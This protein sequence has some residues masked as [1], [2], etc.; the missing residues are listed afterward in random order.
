MDKIINPKSS[1][2]N[3]KSKIVNLLIAA[4]I[5]FNACG[6]WIDVVPD[7]IAT[8]DM[9]FNSRVQALKYLK[10]CYSFMMPDN[11]GNINQDPAMLGDE[12]WTTIAAQPIYSYTGLYLAQGMMSATSPL[13]ERWGHCYQALRDCNIFM[14]NV[15]RAPDLPAWERDQWIAEAKVLKAYYHF[16]LVRM[17][18]PVPI[19]RENIPVSADVSK[20]KVVR[21]PVDDCFRY[22]V[23]LLDE[24]IASDALPSQVLDENRELGRITKPIAMALK[25]KILV[26][27]A[28][29]LYNGNSDFETLCNHDGTQ[30]FNATYDETKWQKAVVACKEAIDACFDANIQLYEF[31]NTGNNPLT[32][33]I[34]TRMSL[35]NAFTL[36]WNSEIIWAN[37]QSIIA[38]NRW[39]GTGR[40]LQTYAGV[41]LNPSFREN[42]EAHRSLGVPLHIAEIFYTNHGVPLAE[43]R[44][45][46]FS[47]RY[48]L[49]TALAAERLY[50]K[51]GNV[52]VD[53]HFDR[54]PRFYAWVGFDCGIWY[55][56][57]RYDDQVEL[58]TLECKGGDVDRLWGTGVGYLPKKYIHYT[59]MVT[60]NTY[61]ISVTTYPWP[62]MR[63]SEL[64][65]LYA[66]AINEA[67]G[68]AEK[69]SVE[70]FEYIDRVRKRAGL[71]GIKASWSAYSKQPNKFATKEGMREIIRQERMI[72]LAFEGHRFWDVRRWKTAPQVYSVPI[73]GWSVLERETNDFYQR[74]VVY[75]KKFR[76]RD[77]FWP[78]RNS[79]LDRNPNLVQ[80]IGW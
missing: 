62:L 37:T 5:G 28:S 34:A 2:V 67:E 36:R 26:T 19:I 14:E 42:Y 65:L 7:G 31:P 20:V 23:E 46:D 57:G 60:D 45:R 11:S 68:P 9:A 17:Y 51:A 18:G 70:L 63:L 50:V 58:W 47:A 43:D 25:A 66:E 3:L 54:E 52:T 49:R 35:R 72:E 24:V 39:S 69:N 64:Y 32:D 75:Q 74:K 29:P 78:I 40:D 15:G 38:A 10:T 13:F 53:L 1:I 6:D 41:I 12:L 22:M 80:N 76:N 21:E 77:Y 30:L 27:A 56:A 4:L 61:G 48:N 44:T 16:I 79:E 59:N 8:I 33:I 73:D 71:E 55:G